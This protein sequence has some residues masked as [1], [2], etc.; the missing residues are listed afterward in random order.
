MTNEWE[1]CSNGN[2]AHVQW[3]EPIFL[4]PRQLGK[5]EKTRKMPIIV[6]LDKFILKGN[7]CNSPFTH[8]CT[9]VILLISLN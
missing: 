7:I 1:S 9:L 3:N 6:N 2:G 5:M 8:F 4:V